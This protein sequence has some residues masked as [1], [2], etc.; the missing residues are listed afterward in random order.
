MRD[1]LTFLLMAPPAELAP[2]PINRPGAP[3]AR[4]KAEIDAVLAGSEPLDKQKLR[5][6]EII[7]VSGPKDHGINE[8][9][10]PD[11]QKRWSKLLALAPQVKVD[12]AE[13]WPSPEQLRN[14]SV[15]VWYSA[16]PA[17]TPEKAK[18]LDAF[19]A[20]GGGM[21]Y[22]HFAV[23]GQRAPEQLAERIGL[24]WRDGSKFRHGPVDLRFTRDARHPIVRNFTAVKFEDEAY[25]NLLGDLSKIQVLATSDEEGEARPLL[26]AYEHNQ[27]RVFGSI[28]GHYS[29]TFDDP[30][31]RTLVL[32]GIAWTAG[33]PVDRFN[34]LVTIG[35]RV[36]E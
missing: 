16:N 24:A 1:L 34:D 36:S 8:H 19:Q 25:W 23:N 3:P 31:F 13:V 27:G 32:R 28:L 17:W 18:E 11:W 10:Y 30:L 12:T 33:E 20:R 26:W 29:W 7:L 4:T 2:A 6:R 9:D 35:A 14:A 21:V 15:L 5:P 22:L